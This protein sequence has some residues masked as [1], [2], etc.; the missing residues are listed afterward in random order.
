MLPSLAGQYVFSIF[1]AIYSQYII[2]LFRLASALAWEWKIRNP[3]NLPIWRTFNSSQP[4]TNIDLYL[5][6]LLVSKNWPRKNLT[7][8]ISKKISKTSISNPSA[9][10]LL[11]LAM[12][13]IRDSAVHMCSVLCWKLWSTIWHH[14][15]LNCLN[16]SIKYLFSGPYFCL[17]ICIIFN[18][19]I[20]SNFNILQL[21]V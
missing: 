16:Y 13:N 15:L 12:L 19:V 8:L 21:I 1:S 9:L 10:W 4:K 17:P 14:S 2:C 7:N 3:E 20:F 11:Q 18:K 5:L 6:H